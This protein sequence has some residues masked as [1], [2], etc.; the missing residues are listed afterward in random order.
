MRTVL[1]ALMCLTVTAAD[2]AGRYGT[3]LSGNAMFSV[4]RTDPEGV[5]NYVVGA[6]DM[7][8]A[9]RTTSYCT[10][11]SMTTVQ[12][13]DIVCKWLAQNPERRDLSAAALTLAAIGEAF[14]CGSR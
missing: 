9:L 12:A 10:P 6:L 13:R 7:A 14:P 1:A 3:F 2:A 8:S 11:P 4:C 5:M